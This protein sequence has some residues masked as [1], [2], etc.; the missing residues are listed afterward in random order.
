MPK[1]KVY[2]DV[3]TSSFCAPPLTDAQIES[4]V[5]SMSELGIPPAHTR[6]LAAQGEDIDPAASYQHLLALGE[7]ADCPPPDAPES[8]KMTDA[9]LAEAAAKAPKA[10][11]IADEE[12][13]R[14]G[15]WLRWPS[16]NRMV[17]PGAPRDG[18]PSSEALAL[19]Q[20]QVRDKKRRKGGTG[21]S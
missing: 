13:P 8:L 14:D 15:M 9:E 5:T 19:H 20:S 11:F 7:V 3:I 10:L 6:W 18:D 2:K 16:A 21:A 1:V 4:I 17:R 12:D